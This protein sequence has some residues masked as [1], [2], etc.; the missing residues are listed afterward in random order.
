M[1]REFDLII[2]DLDGTL[3]QVNNEM[4]RVYPRATIH[5]LARKTGR[6]SRE[7]EPEFLRKKDELQVILNGQPTSTLTL[8]YFYDVGF[9][10]FEDTID[11]MIEVDKYIKPDAKTIDTIRKIREHYPLFLYT[12]NNSKVSDRILNHLGLSELF[13]PEK[14]FTLSD[15]GQLELPR[16]EKLRFVKPGLRGF[17]HILQMHSVNPDR[18][19][20]V[21][22]S[23]TSDITPAQRSGIHTYHITN[24]IS[25][26][27]L[28]E[29]LGV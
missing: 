24:R 10:E 21:G 7:I 25:F 8:L 23:E 15:A 19:L 22:D 4:D 17:A 1:K 13:P 6:D 29:W 3:Y 14:R 26:Y 9:E 11:S 16:K 2:F 28:P 18:V 5:L 27:R 12:T 20:M